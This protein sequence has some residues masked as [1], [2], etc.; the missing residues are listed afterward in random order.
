M[1]VTASNAH[2]STSASS[3]ATSVVVAAPVD[4]AAP[5]ISGTPRQ[6]QELTASTGTWTAYPEASYTY[7]WERCYGKE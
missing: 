3:G 4:T 5:A 2:G 1:K 6:G 7:Q